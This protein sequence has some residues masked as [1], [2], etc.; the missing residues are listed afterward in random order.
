V[1]LQRAARSVSSR[2]DEHTRIEQ[3]VRVERA[4]GG[5]ERLGEQGRALAVVP[6]TV[7]AA[8]CVVMG[9]RAAAGD[10]R[11]E[12]RGFD[13][14]PLLDQL[15]MPAGRM[16]REIGSRPVQAQANKITERLYLLYPGWRTNSENE[17][18]KF[19]PSKEIVDRLMYDRRAAILEVTN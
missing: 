5:L 1:W 15:P 9:H 12:R 13:R 11:V 7:V 17:L 19:I 4:L 10:H 18:E 3:A 14:M 8:D 16:E 2:V 6:G